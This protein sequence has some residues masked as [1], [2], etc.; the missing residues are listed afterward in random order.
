MIEA[1]ATTSPSMVS[2]A[3]PVRMTGAQIAIGLGE[4]ET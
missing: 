2:S 3:L 4:R 1:S